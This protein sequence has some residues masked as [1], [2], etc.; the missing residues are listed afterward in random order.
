MAKR[1]KA[2]IERQILASTVRHQAYDEKPPSL[3]AMIIEHG[4]WDKIPEEAWGRHADALEAW[5][6]AG[7][8][9]WIRGKA[10]SGK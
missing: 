8:E 9:G 2:E 4:G 1:S 10:K 3:E 5:F 7:R 6:Q